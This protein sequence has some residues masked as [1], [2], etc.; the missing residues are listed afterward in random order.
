MMAWVG[1]GLGV[2]AGALWAVGYAVTD[3]DTLFEGRSVYDGSEL[4]TNGPVALQERAPVVIRGQLVPALLHCIQTDLADSPFV[5]ALADFMATLPLL[6]VHWVQSEGRRNVAVHPLALFGTN[7]AAAIPVLMEYVRNTDETLCAS[8]A[9]VPP[10]IG[11][12]PE[13]LVS[14]LIERLKDEA[15]NGRPYRV[16]ALGSFG[17]R[18]R[19]TVPHRIPLL[20]DRSSKEIVRAVPEALKV[21]D[22]EAAARAGVK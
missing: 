22:P 4:A 21:M 6:D 12:D 17:P 15:G 9:E 5:M 20:Q 8:G 16:S 19:A 18:A 10:V 7:A 14:L 2:M 13:R 11:A 1:P 3:R